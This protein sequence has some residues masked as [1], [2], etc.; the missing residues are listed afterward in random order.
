V[1][2]VIAKLGDVALWV[3]DKA[4]EY[5]QQEQAARLKWG[6]ILIVAG[7]VIGMLAAAFALLTFHYLLAIIVQ[8]WVAELTVAGVAGAGG[9]AC[10]LAGLKQ[11]RSVSVGVPNTV[12][13][14]KENLQ[15]VRTS[16]K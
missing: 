13:N 11:L 10:L 6:A 2:N 16:T 7:G 12:A 4:S 14:I 15:W 3:Q 9:T 5:G 1:T 8:P